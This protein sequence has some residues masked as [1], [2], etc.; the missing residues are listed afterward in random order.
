M[1]IW[2]LVFLA[3]C[4]FDPSGLAFDD[5]GGVPGPDAA[6]PSDAS[7]PD[8]DAPTVVVIDAAGTPDAVE[9]PDADPPDACID[10]PCTSQGDCTAA[11]TCCH[12]ALDICVEGNFH[13]G[14][15]WPADDWMSCP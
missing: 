9:V 15:C 6:A 3:A 10:T 8:E 2:L 5:A 13:S 4:T 14:Q 11:F 1:R 12:P 7:A